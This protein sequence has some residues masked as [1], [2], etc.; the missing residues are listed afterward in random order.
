MKLMKSVA[1]ALAIV[2]LAACQPNQQVDNVHYDMVPDLLEMKVGDVEFV[3]VLPN[4]KSSVVWESADPAVATVDEGMVTA[5]G[6]GSTT[7]TAKIGEKTVECFVMVTGS[8]GQTFALNRYQVTLD[9]G[10]EF[11]IE[12]RSTYS[13]QFTYSVNK[14]GAEFVEVSET[15][16]I[17]AKK[18]GV[19]II[20]VKDGMETLNVNVA[21]NHK[22]G[23]YKMVWS[24]EF[25]GTEIDRNTW[26][27]EVNGNG[28]GNKEAQYYL[29]RRE[30]IRVED[31]FLVIQMR[32]DGYGGKA[33][34][35][36][37]MQSRGKKE[38]TYGKIEARISFPSGKGLW[39]AFW[40]LG[41]KGGW[42]SCGE[43]DIIEH[44][45][46]NPKMSSFAVHTLDKNGLNGTNWH[47]VYNAEN[48]MENEFH[49][50]GIEW[51]QEEEN[52]CDK[53][54]F[55]VDGERRAT[56]A[57]NPTLVDQNRYWPFNTPHFIIFNMAIGGTM[58]GAID[59]SLFDQGDVLMKVD[60]VRVW[61]REEIE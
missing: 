53:I 3:E 12:A 33:Y 34:T 18:P 27:I 30:N 45:G 32:K 57:E 11:Q 38:F 20:Y 40:M 4:P 50:Y 43:I 13:N 31:G 58:G 29:D 28:G 23:E 47:S 55:L 56:V 48:S 9:K 26:N 49:T 35:S 60:W 17:K 8:A 5:E 22:W 39:P 36:G 6:I 46:S 10:G 37:R 2:C 59:N 24:D 44:I 15:G 21:V 19:A 42:P 51:T 41:T 1:L 54:H 61:Q 52:G 25:D 7:V 16:L 14:A